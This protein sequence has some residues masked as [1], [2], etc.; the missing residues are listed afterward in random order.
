MYAEI[1]MCLL[2]YILEICLKNKEAMIQAIDSR[3]EFGLMVVQ[4][5]TP[6]VLEAAGISK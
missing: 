2:L 3:R 4:E 5:S 6:T 1:M